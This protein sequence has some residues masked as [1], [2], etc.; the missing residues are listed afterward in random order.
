MPWH[1]HLS[2]FALQWQHR[3]QWQREGLCISM[4]ATGWAMMPR[5]HQLSLAQPID[6]DS[7]RSSRAGNDA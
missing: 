7:S 1:H 2:L 6:G 3:Q 5:H 4:T